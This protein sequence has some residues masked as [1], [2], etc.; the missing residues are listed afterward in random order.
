[1]VPFGCTASL[2]LPFGG[3][4]YGLGQGTSR[5]AISLLGI[6]IVPNKLNLLG[7][8]PGLIRRPW[9]GMIVGKRVVSCEE[10][11]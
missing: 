4:E 8:I 3:G 10:E 1:M 2:R 7:T 9:D 6:K 5:R 11:E